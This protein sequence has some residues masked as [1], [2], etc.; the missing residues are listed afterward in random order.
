MF[1]P[2]ALLGQ[3]CPEF[4]EHQGFERLVGGDELGGVV[5]V[6]APVHVGNQF[7]REVVDARE[8]R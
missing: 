3:E 2:E 8:A 7:Q 4:A 5:A 1:S 6:D